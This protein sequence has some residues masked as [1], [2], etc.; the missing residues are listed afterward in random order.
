MAPPWGELYWM[1]NVTGRC[2]GRGRKGIRGECVG[3]GSE[4][5]VEIWENERVQACGAAGSNH[6]VESVRCRVHAV[7]TVLSL[8]LVEYPTRL[9]G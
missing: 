9:R 6:R 8:S 1:D 5:Q 7:Q 4:K 3:G 2:L